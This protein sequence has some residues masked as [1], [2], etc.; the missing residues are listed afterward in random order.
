MLSIVEGLFIFIAVIET[1]L[2]ILGN[3][4]IGLVNCIDFVKKKKCSVIGLILIGLATSRMFL[5][6]IIITDGFI[7]ALSPDTYSHGNLIE[8][9]SYLWV[10]INH[11]SVFFATTLSIFYF[12][13]IANFSHRVFLCWKH[14]INKVFS[15]L[16]GLLL[17]SWLFIFPSLIKTINDYKA[18]NKNITWYLNASKNDYITYQFLCN[19]EIIFFFTLSLVTCFLLIISLWRHNRH[20]QSNV[21][22][23]RDSSSEAHVRA[24]KVLISFSILLI[25]HF[26]G[27]VIEISCN[28][29]PEKKVLMMFGVTISA[30]YPWGHS[31]ILILANNKLK[32]A[33]LK[34]LQLLK[35]CRKEKPLRAP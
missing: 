28:L 16:M 15:L 2:G 7:K 10:I 1:I 33:S 11:S 13:K 30:L 14:R 20:M 4:F 19:L 35:C 12:L 21:L 34:L 8:Y 22:G 31:F 24:I 25:L 18:K 6:W 32:Q 17:M 5:I 3:G 23:V 26:I 29:V 9:I 27:I